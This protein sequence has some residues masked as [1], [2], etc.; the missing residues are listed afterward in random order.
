MSQN[1]KN[2]SGPA[3]IALPL[4]SVGGSEDHASG[5]VEACATVN[6]PRLDSFQVPA[7]VDEMRCFEPDQAGCVY[8]EIDFGEVLNQTRDPLRLLRRA[9]NVLVPDGTLKATFINGRNITTVGALLA[10]KWP[11]RQASGQGQ[12]NHDQLR[13]YTRREA[14]KLLYRAGYG[15]VQ[16]LPE[17]NPELK[18]WRRAGMPAEV[19][20]GPLRFSARSPA[21]AEEFYTERFQAVAERNDRPDRGLTSIVIATHNQLQFTRVCLESIRFRTDEPYELIVVDNGST[22]GTVEYLRSCSDVRLIEN[23]NNRGFPAAANQ[24]ILASRGQQI[25]L[26]NNDVLVTTGWLDR[27]LRA[28]Y[29]EEHGDN[30][31][32]IGLVGP[33][34]NAVSGPQQVSVEYDDLADLDGFAWDWGQRYD[35]QREEIDRLVGFCLL[36]RRELI[37][38]VGVLDERFGIGN[39]E[40]DDFCRRAMLAGYKAV[41]ARDAFIHHFGHRSFAGAGIDL[42]ALLQHNALIYREK[43]QARNGGRRHFEHEVKATVGNGQ[44]A[45]GRLTR[46][47]GQPTISCCIIAR[48]NERTIRACISSVKPWVDEVIVVDTGSTDATPDIC[49]ELGCRVYHMTWPDSFAEARNES[50]KYATSE[51]IFVIDTDDVLDDANGRLMH[52]LLDN[53]PP[54]VMAYIG[55]VLCPGAGPD[56]HLDVTAVDQVKLFRNRP[57]LRYEFRIHEQVLPSIRRIGGAIAFSDLNV[58]HSGA[59]RT[60]EGYRRKLRR[61]LRLLKMELA[62]RPGCPFTLFNLGMTYSDAKKYRRGVHWLRASIAASQPGDSHLRKAYALLASSLFQLGRYDEAAEAIRQGRELYPNDTELLFREGL[63]FQN[64]GCYRQAARSYQAALSTNEPPHFASLEV[65]LCGFKTRFNLARVYG[66]MGNLDAEEAEWRKVVAEAP[67]FRD[68]WRALMDCLMERH[69]ASGVRRK[70]ENGGTVHPQVGS[71]LVD[72]TLR[73]FA[74]EAEQLANSLLGDARLCGQGYLTLARLA[75]RRGDLAAAGTLLAAGV[76]KCPDDAMPLRELSAWLWQHAGPAEAGTALEELIRRTSG[77]AGARY[78][79]ALTMLPFGR[80]KEAIASLKQAVR[81]DPYYEAARGL[82]ATL[83]ASV[84]A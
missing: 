32:T 27:L 15:H 14:E 36:F 22:D 50:L 9:H 65:G 47:D 57:D 38:R 84:A 71:T 8:R 3:T 25:L 19:T 28:L 44:L 60:P 64:G 66:Q 5:S 51:W 52:Q 16:L 63:Y 20:A 6:D 30:Q 43:W 80:V 75:E 45:N 46:P 55:R 68:G 49:R 79:L 13:V 18:R 33:C 54:E 48:D 11:S 21:E 41:I 62:E 70:E 31:T 56:G 72:A 83:E 2:V 59:D 42:N 26:L 12:R 61:D 53:A 37:D 1:S 67:T 77:D 82:L 39:F 24:G 29:A 4:S 74:A 23:A 76:E 81:I 73:D 58:V 78:N 69:Q 40:D 10:G 34:S 17:E 35:G 7:N